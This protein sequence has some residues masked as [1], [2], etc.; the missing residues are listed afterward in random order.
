MVCCSLV[1][2]VRRKWD[3]QFGKNFWFSVGIHVDHTDPS[4]TLH[5]PIFIIAA[6]RLKQPGFEFSIRSLI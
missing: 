2:M 5:L 3:I 4:I 6:G 1:F